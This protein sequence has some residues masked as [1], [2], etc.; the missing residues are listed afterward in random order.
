MYSN[1]TEQ[2]EGTNTVPQ[3]HEGVKVDGEMLGCVKKL[4]YDDHDVADTIKFPDF[5]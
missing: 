1:N 4:K 2:A 5:A 3:I